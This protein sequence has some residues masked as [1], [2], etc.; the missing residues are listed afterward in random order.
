MRHFEGFS[1]RP[2]CVGEVNAF[3]VQYYRKSRVSLKVGKAPH[4]RSIQRILNA[5]KSVTT[6]IL[7]HEFNLL[8]L[9]KMQIFCPYCDCFRDRTQDCDIRTNFFKYA[10]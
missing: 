9:L 1:I 8:S 3:V 6:K 7:S 2:L 4:F 10:N 5:P